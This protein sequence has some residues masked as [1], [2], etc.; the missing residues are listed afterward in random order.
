MRIHPRLIS[1]LLLSALPLCAAELPVVTLEEAL[2]AAEENSIQLE[3]AAVRLNQAIR[4]QDAIMTTYMP[5]LSLSAS[6]ST[7]VPFQDIGGN[8]LGYSGLSYSLGANASFTL[9]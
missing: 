4:R 5:T 2:T 6:V 8:P 1:I 9:G 7:D 3:E